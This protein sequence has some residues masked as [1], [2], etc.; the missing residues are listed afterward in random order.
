MNAVDLAQPCAYCAMP[1]GD[2]RARTLWCP[3]LR[4]SKGMRRY[5]PKY[6][7]AIVSLSVR[8]TTAFVAWL[9]STLGL[10]PIPYGTARI[11]GLQ[12]RVGVRTRAHGARAKPRGQTR[13]TA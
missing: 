5:P 7:A 8:E 12:N 9:R 1:L 11:L 6:R 2:H 10:G 13:T 4:P 3:R